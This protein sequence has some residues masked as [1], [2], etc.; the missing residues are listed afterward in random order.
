MEKQGKESNPQSASESKNLLIGCYSDGKEAPSLFYFDSVEKTATAILTETNPSYVT[1]YDGFYY[2]VAEHEAGVL[3]TLNSKFEVVSRIL[4]MGDGPCQITIDDAG[5]YI[6]V[7]NYNSASVLICRLENHIPTS[8]HSLIKHE[9]NSVNTDR[10]TSPHPHSSVFSQ[11]GTVLFIAD[12]GTDILY[13]YNFTPE[14]VQFV[15]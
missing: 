3:L 4:T 7:S 13:Y 8:V 1:M 15:K 10:Q 12:L 9:G 5:K 6:V 11:D 14:T 2:V